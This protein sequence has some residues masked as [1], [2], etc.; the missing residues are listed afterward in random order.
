[1]RQVNPVGLILDANSISDLKVLAKKAEDA[2]FDSV[3]ATELYRTTF[4]QLSAVANSTNKIKLGTA[5][6]LAFVR[7]PLITSLTALDLDEISDGRLILGLGTGAK[8]T[9]EMWHG[10]NHGKPVT[11]IKEC[12]ELIRLL[13]SGVHN[14]DPLSFKGE[15]Y[16]ISTKGYHRAF[17]PIRDSFPIYLAGVG[18][19]MISAS[20]EV[21]D[22]YL[23]HVVCSLGYIKQVVSK[24]IQSGL[25]KAGRSKLDFNTSSIIT[26]AISENKKD[27]LE[28]ARATIAFYATVRTYEPP[29]KLHGFREQT[30]QVRDAFF[31]RDTKTMINRVSDDMVNT[32]AIVGTPSECRKKV[33]EYRE[34]LD[35]PIL[36]APHYYLDF[37]EVKQYQNAIL[38]TFGR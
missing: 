16:N 37:E 15:Y 29:F 23:G 18:S 7:S 2:N 22:G 28:A 8:R 19:N 12:I 9:N 30:E 17:K 14:D 33:D 20:A 6:A 38:D 32:F 4:Q 5:V 10:I 31:K 25:K 26:C 35:L 36:S 24:S 1:M 3:W 34:Y 11:R 13:S 21:A 27:A